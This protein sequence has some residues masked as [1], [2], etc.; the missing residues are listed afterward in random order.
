MPLRRPPRRR[1]Q[2]A[3]VPGPDADAAASLLAD[4]P[5]SRA[6]VATAAGAASGADAVVLLVPGSA[7]DAADSLGLLTALAQ[8][9]AAARSADPASASRLGLRLLRLEAAARH[10]DGAP[11]GRAAHRAAAAVHRPETPAAAAVSLAVAAR[12]VSTVLLRAALGRHAADPRR[13]MS[14][15]AGTPALC[16]D[17]DAD[18][19]GRAADVLEALNARAAASAGFLRAADLADLA[20][21]AA[22]HAVVTSALRSGCRR[23]AGAAVGALEPVV[24]ELGRILTDGRSTAQLRAALAGTMPAPADAQGTR[25]AHADAAGAGDDAPARLAEQRALLAETMMTSSVVAAACRAAD[26]ARTDDGALSERGLA[27]LAAAAALEPHAVALLAALPA[28]S[29]PGAACSA[30]SARAAALAA[31]AFAHLERLGASAP[32]SPEGAGR[33]TVHH[34]G[35]GALLDAA[36]AVAAVEHGDVD[37]VAAI[38]GLAARTAEAGDDHHSPRHAG[39]VALDVALARV[40]GSAAVSA[41]PAS[42]GPAPA[43]SVTVS[44]G[45]WATAGDTAEA[46][47]AAWA[48]ASARNP[49]AAA[50]LL[51][52][53]ASLAAAGGATARAAASRLRASAGGVPW[54]DVLAAST[55]P[56][57]LASG[58]L[59]RGA[60]AAGPRPL[61]H[62]GRAGAAPAGRTPAGSLLALLALCGGGDGGGLAG[63]I[64]RQECARA[65]GVRPD[66]VAGGEAAEAAAAGLDDVAGGEAAEAA[67]AGLDDVAGGEAAAALS[68]TDDAVDVL[69][70]AAAVEDSS[71]DE[72]SDSD[73]G[74]DPV[75]G[76]ALAAP[77][78]EPRP[79]TAAAEP[80]LRAAPPDDVTLAA[81]AFPS[82]PDDV[83]LAAAAFASSPDDV[84]L[85]AAAF[86]SSPLAGLPWPRPA[87]PAL[88]AD[89]ADAAAE[90]GVPS[91]S[92]RRFATPGVRRL[93]RRSRFE[94]DE[95][96][97]RCAV[98]SLT[99]S[100][101][102][103][104]PPPPTGAAPPSA[105]PAPDDVIERLELPFGY[106]SPA[107]G[108]FRESRRGMERAT[109]LSS[110]VAMPPLA[111]GGPRLLHPDAPQARPGRTGARYLRYLEQLA[112]G[113]R[114]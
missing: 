72:E 41:P 18:A 97:R 105:R 24:A 110:A 42:P 107:S 59:G 27:L 13:W 55:G 26:A 111:M 57:V 1:G 96:V 10:R 51:G 100:H 108:R 2:P 95:P 76:P 102:F 79:E 83:T 9:L 103:L 74:P 7:L 28:T 50:A 113:A 19:V 6:A 64:V 109:S 30:P 58:G 98:A 25:A 88:A 99:G 40:L 62:L 60:A 61:T 78:A 49:G 39:S 34:G 17:A 86:P 4:H 38:A 47:S 73:A 54:A 21:S 90:P 15:A 87:P 29:A 69:M 33:L 35:A 56:R 53:A 46:L 23:R 11:A 94:D 45:A 68:D 43:R 85:A 63:S 93:S 65:L 14:P 36:A 81:A 8:G 71:S 16:R 89:P 20:S 101:S 80:P 106:E 82:S 31:R 66:D 5:S 114:A 67:A 84:T 44:A 3:S 91:G 77:A 12:A 104:G 92:H 48:T 32:S 75:A 70:G 52:D 37:V 112:E 22:A